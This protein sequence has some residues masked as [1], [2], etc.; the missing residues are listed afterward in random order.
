MKSKLLVELRRTGANT[1]TIFFLKPEL[2]EMVVAHN[3]PVSFTHDNSI[4][5]WCNQPKAMLQIL[6]ECGFISS[7]REL[8]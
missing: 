6:F 4:P 7:Q 5:E 3:I 2:V 1:T 8:I